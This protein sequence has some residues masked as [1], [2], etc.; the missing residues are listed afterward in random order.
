[1]AAAAEYCLRTQAKIPAALA[2]LHNF[3]RVYD[4]DDE[5]EEDGDNCDDED[6]DAD[7]SLPEIPLVAENLGYHISQAEKD[8]ASAKRDEIAKAMWA[9]YRETL[10]VRGMV[11]T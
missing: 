2:V 10:R 8:R 7:I 9:D 11:H 4:P 3:V 5:A 6:D 1:M